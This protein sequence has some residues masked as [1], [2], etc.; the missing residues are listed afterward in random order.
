M[1]NRLLLLTI[2]LLPLTAQVASVHSWG[3]GGFSNNPANPNY[4]THD[5]IAEHAL[6]WLPQHEKQLIL[7]NVAAYLYGTELPDNASQPNGIGDTS[8][9]HVYFFANGTLQDNSS[10]TRAQE[11]YNKAL[12]YYRSGDNASASRELGTVTHYVS[13]LASYGHVMGAETDWG[14]EEHHAAYE[15][16]VSSRTDN[17]TSELNTY[18]S[19]DGTLSHMT[20]YA[21]SLELANNT[22]FDDGGPYTCKWMD[23]SYNW[24]DLQFR[25]RAGESLNLAVNIITDVLHSFHL[26]ITEHHINVPYWSQP[27]GYYCGPASLQ[28]VFDYYGEPIPQTEIAEVAKTTGPGTYTVGLRRAAHFSNQST[29]AGTEMPHRITGYTMRTLGYAALEIGGMTIEQL[30]TVIDSDYPVIALMLTVPDGFGHFRVVTGYDETFIFTNDP[31][32]YGGGFGGINYKLT[33]SDFDQLWD[34]SGHWAMVTYPWFITLNMPSS[35]NPRTDFTVTANVTYPMP[36]IFQPSYPASAC[37]TTIIPPEGV[38]LTEGQNDTITLPDMLPGSNTQVS[39]IMKAKEAGYFKISVQAEGNITGFDSLSPSPEE[40][41]DRIGTIN[42]SSFLAVGPEGHDTEVVQLALSRNVVSKGVPEQTNVQVN[43]TARN[44]SNYQEKFNLTIRANGTE[45]H[46]E[47]LTAAPWSN[48]Y[49]EFNFN[50]TSLDYGNYTIIAETEIMQDETNTTNNQLTSSILITILGDLRSDGRIDIFDVV[51]VAIVYGAR[52][53]DAN[54]DPS[55][56]LLP[57]GNIDQL[58]LQILRFNFGKTIL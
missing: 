11:E 55:A 25:D 12:E 17:Y 28:M 53:G 51:K 35:V 21:A 52:Q 41:T 44:R 3:N 34:Y 15:D 56:D 40:Y 27:N 57:D 7:D 33:Y 8:K 49:L 26:E 1:R 9:H 36:P 32:N 54:Y 46:K 29:S 37:R 19:Y 39:W 50:T 13:D 10:A 30:K 16:Y 58:D 23:T 43:I 18:L 5:W 47:T 6:D 31:W 4:G 45:I 14:A 20:A 22:T 42:S 48:A 38:A 24:T 2:I